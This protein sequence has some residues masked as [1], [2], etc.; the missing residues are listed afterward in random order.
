MIY[1]VTG[2]PGAGKTL[3]AVSQAIARILGGEPGQVEGRRLVVGGVP[4]LLLDH[5]LLDVPT[6]DPE[7]KSPELEERAPSEP[8]LEVPYSG[9]TW[10]QWCRP[11]D[12]I[13]IDEC[14]R[15]FRPMASGRRV[16]AHIAKLETH[17][18]YGIDILLITQHPMLLHAN[19]RNLVGSHEHVRRLWGTHQTVVY[20][21]DHVSNPER[22]AQAQSRL[23][24]HDKRAFTRYKSAEVHNKPRMRIPA[25][26]LLFP[27]I[28]VGAVWLISRGISG[29]ASLG[30]PPAARPPAA[31]ASAPGS[32]LGHARPQAPAP[33]PTPEP[34]TPQLEARRQLGQVQA[35]DT[36]RVPLEQLQTVYHCVP[37]AAAWCIC[38]GRASIVHLRDPHELCQR[39]RSHGHTYGSLSQPELDAWARVTGDRAGI[40]LGQPLGAPPLDARDVLRPQLDAQAQRS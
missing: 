8:P 4:G 14:Q 13:V 32:V 20:S 12:L 18:H 23:V 3:Y 22:T 40:D 27:L 2:T 24:R 10:W 11:G 39:A 6:W 17:R 36:E 5:E 33:T 35:D 1:L 9:A 26:V 19:V 29:A 16:P 38:T 37:T 15:L 25:L 34:D 28:V 7:A 31:A 30:K 21:W